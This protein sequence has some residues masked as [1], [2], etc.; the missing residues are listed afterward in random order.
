MSE[1]SKET[2]IKEKPKKEKKKTKDKIKKEKKK[3]EGKFKQSSKEFFKGIWKFIS[4]FLKIILAPFWYTGV[5]FVKSIKFLKERGD[6]ALT[7]K[8]KKYLSLIP[9]LF[10]MMCISIIV[11]F[12]IF[13]FELLD[14]TIEVISDVGFWAAVGDFFIR[15][16]NGIYWLLQVVFV[17]FF[18]EMIILNFADFMTNENFYWATLILIVLIIVITGLGILMYHAL[19]TRTVIKA[20]AKFFKKI[21]QYPKNFFTYIR[22]NIILKYVVGEKYIETRS[23]NFF[24]VTVLIQFILT[25]I[26]FVFSLALGIYNYITEV[27][28]GADILRY[29]LIFGLLLFIF[30]GIFSTWFFIRVF[31]VTTATSEKYTI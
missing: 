7:D 9:A 24:W 31:G 10:F 20:I 22:E 19:K 8:D 17:T 26:M 25:A 23:K 30:I 27:W 3:R 2:E 4:F 1:E 11:I 15:I 29:S 5:L 18:W 28:R 14:D 16:G 12:L 6:H 21:A 13:Y